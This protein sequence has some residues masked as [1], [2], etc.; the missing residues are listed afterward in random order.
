MVVDDYIEVMVAEEIEVGGLTIHDSLPAELGEINVFDPLHG[1][2]EK[3]NQGDVLLSC[4]LPDIG[5]RR[6][7]YGFQKQGL[8]GETARNGV[9]I[10]FDDN[11]ES[12]LGGEEIPQL[13]KLHPD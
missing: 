12:V 9:G 7:F 8:Q 11:E 5:R 1:D 3:P 10:R 4:N 2:I 6:V 13:V